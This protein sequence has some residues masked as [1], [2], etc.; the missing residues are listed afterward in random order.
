M[1]QPNQN[2]PQSEVTWPLTL[3]FAA[4]LLGC[5]LLSL[6]GGQSLNV[7][8]AAVCY[9]CGVCG[10]T[11]YFCLEAAAHRRSQ[12]QVHA[13]RHKSEQRLSRRLHAEAISTEPQRLNPVADNSAGTV[14]S[15]MDSQADLATCLGATHQPTLSV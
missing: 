11:I 2:S 9:L 15:A 4:V 5:V 7:G 6:G 1:N 3:R 10:L 13:A 14:E 8:V 12:G